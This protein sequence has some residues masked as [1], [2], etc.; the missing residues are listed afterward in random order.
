MGDVALREGDDVVAVKDFGGIMREA[1]PA[2]ARG[3]V[4]S[5]PWLA[6]ARVTFEL[7]DFWHG[8]RKVSVDVQP[9]EVAAV[10]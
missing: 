2:G 1:I 8:H 5:A 4:E 6:P 7:Y 3:R 9:D 10:R